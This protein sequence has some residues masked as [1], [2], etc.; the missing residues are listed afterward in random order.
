MVDVPGHTAGA[1]DD[2]PEW[3]QVLALLGALAPLHLPLHVLSLSQESPLRLQPISSSAPGSR[4]TASSFPPWCYAPR[5][6]HHADLP[7]S[8][9]SDGWPPTGLCACG[10]ARTSEPPYRCAHAWP[11]A[12]PREAR[13]PSASSDSPIAE[14]PTA[15]AARLRIL[16]Q[17]HLAHGD[18]RPAP[19]RAFQRLLRR[20]FRSRLANL[21]ARAT[22]APP[23]TRPSGREGDFP[24]H[25]C[26]LAYC[27][28]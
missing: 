26:C 12:A 20:R 27:C 7:S 11:A 16:E 8:A 18:R 2:S 22:Q 3:Q 14:R 25:R 24:L 17:C 6:A 13:L 21:A 5:P 10:F 28:A 23:M 19:S 9:C 4:A 1:D 15:Q